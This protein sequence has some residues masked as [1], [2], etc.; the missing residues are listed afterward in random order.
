MSWAEYTAGW[1]DLHGGYDLESGSRFVR[2]WLRLAYASGRLA[3]RAGATPAVVTVAGVVLS[4]GVPLIVPAPGGP[5][6]AAVLVLAAAVADAVDGAVAVLGGRA[7]R[8]GAVYDGVADRIGEAC[9]LVALW[10]LGAP[11]WLVVTGGA[12]A[13]L[14]EYLRAR[15][16]A[17]GM[18]E[19]GVV[20]VAERPT[21]VI[22]AVV[23]LLACGVAGLLLR[24]A[25]A[26]ATVTAAVW[27]LFAV[28]GLIQ[29]YRGVRAALR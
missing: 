10:R 24:Q 17:A 15:A 22:V 1:R 20:T 6:L 28:V 27:A 9:W 25:P 8:L 11:G 18:A 2:G 4:L 21:R 12:L 23:G 26:A 7:S 3:V 29:L 5:F 19:V 13:W 14:Q 16:G